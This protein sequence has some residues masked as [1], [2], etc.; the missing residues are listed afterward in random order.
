M[1]NYVGMTMVKKEQRRDDY[2]FIARNNRTR[3]LIF[4]YTSNITS[5][6][7]CV[8]INGR[9]WDLRL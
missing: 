8:E 9:H 2:C 6:H 1:N 7:V 5:M 3:S 4:P